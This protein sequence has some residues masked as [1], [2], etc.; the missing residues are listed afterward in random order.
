M[1]SYQYIYVMKNLSKTYPGGKQVLHNIWLSFFPGAKIGVL[2]ANGAGKSTLLKIM[3]GI[4]TEFNGEAWAAEGASVGYL[5]QEPQLD[6]SKNV[7]ENVMDG[8]GETRDLL[9]RFEEISMKFA[10]EMTDD[11]MNALI[12]E[13]AEL[14]EK[15][16]PVTAGIWNARLKLPWTRCAVRRQTRTLQ[17]C[18]AVKNA[19]SRCAVYCFQSR[20]YCCWTNRQTIW[21]PNPSP[22]CSSICM[23][24]REPLSWSHTTVTFWTT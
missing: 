11:E 6:P 10:E 4:E 13:Q 5:P 19:V 23:I 21:T 2:G 12:A 7:M 18:P 9:K 24:I 8:C 16:T 20:I 15:S 17:S 22:G 3:A 14:Q 1:A